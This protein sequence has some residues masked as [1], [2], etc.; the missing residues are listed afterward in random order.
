M[1]KSS[2]ILLGILFSIVL[3]AQNLSYSRAFPT[4][5]KN[6]P[7]QIFKNED[8]SF[9]LL[10]FNKKAHDLTLEKRS[11]FSAEILQFTAL[12]LDSVNSN[13]FDYSN[14]EYKFINYLN[15]NYFVFEKAQIKEKRFILST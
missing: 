4:V 7:L 15:Q 13:I 9:F 5:S 3:H 10:R 14:L 12:R 2:L 11:M 8:S 1:P 6:L